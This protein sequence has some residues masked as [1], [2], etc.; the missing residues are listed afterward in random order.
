MA[1]TKE[2]S[3]VVQKY[4]HWSDK[5][6]PEIKEILKYQLGFHTV[7]EPNDYKDDLHRNTDLVGFRTGKEIGVRIA[8]RIREHK[9]LEPFKHEITL[10]WK[11]VVNNE[12]ETEF[13][14]VMKGWGDIYLY[15]YAGKDTD[16]L[17]YWYIADLHALRIWI[18][19]HLAE[20]GT[21]PEHSTIKPPC[22]AGAEPNISIGFDARKIP[23]FVVAEHSPFFIPVTNGIALADT[24]LSAIV[25]N[26]A[27]T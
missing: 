6:T 4:K 2:H 15:G 23:K 5:Y 22:D 25:E 1:V 14:K 17:A 3:K 26:T 24:G 16:K 13:R 11:F 12:T 27:V 7:K 21:L 10:R 18:Y 20:H 19:D 9:W 8:T